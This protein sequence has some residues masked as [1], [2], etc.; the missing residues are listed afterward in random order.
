MRACVRACRVCKKSRSGRQEIDLVE[1][2]ACGGSSSGGWLGNAKRACKANGLDWIGWMDGWIRRMDGLDWMDWM[3]T[4]RRK[5]EKEE[6]KEKM[7]KDNATQSAHS[8]QYLRGIQ[9]SPQNAK[10]EK[11]KSK[12]YSHSVLNM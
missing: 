10:W 11:S 12:R 9:E 8:I 1:E 5:E 7:K 3:V 6:R 4:R 2:S